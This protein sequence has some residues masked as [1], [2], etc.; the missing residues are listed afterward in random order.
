[1]EERLIVYDYP[2]LITEMIELE[3]SPK[4]R[5]DHPEIFSDGK[6]NLDAFKDATGT[7]DLPEDEDKTPAERRKKWVKKP[8]P[9]TDEKPVTPS[10][11]KIEKHPSEVHKKEKK[12]P[13]PAP[14]ISGL[15][16]ES[17][18]CASGATPWSL[19]WPNT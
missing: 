13:E 1:M 5:V 2:W 9:A 6:I 14:A 15:S 7:S 17:T 19:S 8:K 11:N 18:T 10:E 16:P 4:G 3:E 12:V